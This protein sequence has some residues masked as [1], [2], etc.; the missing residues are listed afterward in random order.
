MLRVDRRRSH[1]GRC[2]VRTVVVSA[3]IDGGGFASLQEWHHSRRRLFST[4]G[5]TSTG[6]H[7]RLGV[8]N[9]LGL[10][11]DSLAGV[12]SVVQMALA[13]ATVFLDLGSGESLEMILEL[14]LVPVDPQRTGSRGEVTH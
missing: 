6:C 9:G 14:N 10:V 12:L 11:R 3:S 5:G 8:I 2:F 4:H 7:A 1:D 13:N